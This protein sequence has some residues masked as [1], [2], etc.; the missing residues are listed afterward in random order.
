MA[1]YDLAGK[2]L[3]IP[4]YRLI[5]VKERN[6]CPVSWWTNDMSHDDWLDEMRE[7]LSLGYMSAKL[8]ARPWRDF[9]AMT[10]AIAAIAPE[11]FRIDAD[12]NSFLLEAG[13]GAAYL[14]ELQKNPRM[15]IFESPI[16]QADV[17]GNKILRAKI[18]RPIAMHYGSPPI[19]TA[20]RDEVCDGFVIG[21]GANNVR[22][23]GTLAAQMN[24]PF[25]LQMVGTRPD[26]RLHAPLWARTLTHA[27]VA[28]RHLP[29]DLRRRSDQG[30][31]RGALR[32]YAGCP[33][34]P[35][36]VSKPDEDAIRPLQGGRGL[37]AGPAAQSLP[38]VVARREQRRVPPS[39]SAT[40]PIQRWAS[41]ACGMTLRP[42]TS[43]LFH[44]GVKLEI[45][46]DDGSQEWD[47]L[48]QRALEAPV[49]EA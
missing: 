45:V 15:D 17:E 34:R 10:R 12:F 25:F 38:R 21:G 48:H 29:R 11:D 5:G 26:D 30:A 49:R 32:L 7:A 23:Q 16:P 18:N 39:A 24:K 33:R 46:P 4:C 35:A 20:L 9:N 31:A 42:A 14:Q 1:I 27:Q 19:Q 6:W 8:K 41:M 3:E 37:C 44:D 13:R 28:G 47:D 2:A 36:W 40:R 22:D 43:R